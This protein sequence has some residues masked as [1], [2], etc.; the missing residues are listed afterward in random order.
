[1]LVGDD[2]K[3]VVDAVRVDFLPGNGHDVVVRN[4]MYTNGD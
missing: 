3:T 1:M 2:W 4:H